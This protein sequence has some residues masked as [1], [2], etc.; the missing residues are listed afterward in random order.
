MDVNKWLPH[1][2]LHAA[3][4]VDPVQLHPA[5][6][7]SRRQGERERPKHGALPSTRAAG[8]Q[9]VRTH[10][11][12]PRLAV[13]PTSQRDER[14]VGPRISDNGR[15]RRP[16]L[17]T[18]GQ[19]EPH[20]LNPMGLHPQPSRADTNPDRLSCLLER[21]HGLA[22]QRPDDHLHVW[23]PDRFTDQPRDL[24]PLAHLTVAQL[25]RQLHGHSQTA[26][27][28]HAAPPPTYAGQLPPSPD[29]PRYAKER[30][31]RSD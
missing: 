3:L 21:L 8:N 20:V 14:Q 10:R 9:R 26:T 25:W 12:S 22:H 2:D 7:Y 27:F 28:T 15:E 24:H 5:L 13:L 11:Q 18:N 16:E 19:R 1:P 4:Q 17:V 6:T 30:E 23:P 29:R 31:R